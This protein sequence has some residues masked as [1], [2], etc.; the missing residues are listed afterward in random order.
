MSNRIVIFDEGSL[1]A[2]R[3][4]LVD[5]TLQQAGQSLSG[6]VFAVERFS[7]SLLAAYWTLSG[8]DYDV[9]RN[10]S[11]IVADV[12]GQ[13]LPPRCVQRVRFIGDQIVLKITEHA[14]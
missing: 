12:I 10:C 8:D 1:I 5:P 2:R 14:K 9:D 7:N 6:R 4:K 3:N 11:S 13:R